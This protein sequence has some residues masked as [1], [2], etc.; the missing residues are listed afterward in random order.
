MLEGS[1]HLVKEL[2][3]QGLSIR[4]IASE[5]DVS[6]SSVHRFIQKIREKEEIR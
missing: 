1:E 4:T 2:F 5:L 3:L 6:K